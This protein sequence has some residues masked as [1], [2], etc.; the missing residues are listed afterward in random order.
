MF[1]G[2][3]IESVDCRAVNIIRFYFTDGT[4]IALETDYM[5]VGIYGI[6]ACATCAKGK[7]DERTGSKPPRGGRASRSPRQEDVSR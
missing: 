6:V 3:T 5:G 4:A 7:G 2:K 1:V